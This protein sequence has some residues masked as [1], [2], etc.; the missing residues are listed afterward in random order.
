M[1]SCSASQYWARLFESHGFAVKLIVAQHVKAFLRNKR[2]KNDERDAEAIYT[3]GIQPDTKFVRI[4]TEEE[5]T[6]ALLH[7]LR[8]A[9]VSERVEISNRIR[10][11]LSEFGIITAKGK[12]NFNNDIQELF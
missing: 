8:K 7:T 9:A 11:I 3:C 5:Q 4:K 6:V 2:V 12:G 10:G 1:E